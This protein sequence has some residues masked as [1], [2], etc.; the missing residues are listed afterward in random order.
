[1]RNYRSE[2]DAALRGEAPEHVPFSIYAEGII[3]EGFDLPSLQAR[4]LALHRR[5]PCYEQHTEDVEWSEEKV[6][7]DVTKVTVKTAIGALTYVWQRATLGTK[8]LEHPI[9]TLDDYRIAEFI[10][11]H[12]SYKPVY[13]KFLAAERETGDAGV[14]VA[15]GPYSPLVDIQLWWLGQEA[16]CY[17]ITDHEDAVL[18]LCEVMRRKHREFFALLAKGPARYVQYCGNVVPGMIGPDRIRRHVLPCWNE[19]G[20]MLHEEGKLYGCHLDAD[21]RQMIDIVRDS[22]FDFI[23][24]FTPPPDCSVSVAEA[25]TVWPNKRLWLNFPSSVHIA[26]DGTIRRAT[27]EILAQ[28]GD[29]K[30]FLLGI[31]EDV[32]ANDMRRSLS[33]ILDVLKEHNS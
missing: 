31:T 23:E 13:D 5:P 20:D 10:V 1:M 3:P 28:A 6:A 9:K 17:E 8:Q 2:I 30:G 29:R 12:T 21:N 19:L 24:A 22:N 32:P 11:Q 4:G 33:C 26:G 14:C 16:F 18:G 15:H 7:E 27:R 25:R